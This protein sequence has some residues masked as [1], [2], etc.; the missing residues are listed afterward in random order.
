MKLKYNFVFQPLHT[1][2]LA[3]TVGDDARAFPGVIQ[4][5]DTGAGIMQMF[6]EDMTVDDAVKRLMDEY[7]ADEADIRNAVE[8]IVSMLEEKDLLE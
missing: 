4:L 3:I 2:T 1:V 8:G 6:L 7:E 5:N